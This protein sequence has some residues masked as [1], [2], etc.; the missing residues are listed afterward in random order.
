MVLFLDINKGGQFE[1][2]LVQF[3][4]RMILSS[5][6]LLVLFLTISGASELTGNETSLN[7][8]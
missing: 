1:N 4:G 5:D 2:N 3:L 7:Q 6:I 8:A